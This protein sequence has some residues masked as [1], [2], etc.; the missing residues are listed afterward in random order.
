M[1]YIARPIPIMTLLLAVLG[2]SNVSTIPNLINQCWVKPPFSCTQPASAI[3]G[4]KGH[5]CWRLYEASTCDT[6]SDGVDGFRQEHLSVTRGKTQYFST[7][8]NPR[9]LFVFFV[10]LSSHQYPGQPVS[11]SIVYT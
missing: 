7:G 10:H 6:D 5:I 11:V 8:F 2:V 3:V 4:K 9:A 1:P